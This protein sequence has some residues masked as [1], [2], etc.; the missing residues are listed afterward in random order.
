MNTCLFVLVLCS[1]LLLSCASN[2]NIII[3][4][5]AGLE[6]GDKVF[7]AIYTIARTPI[8]VDSIVVE[9]DGSFY[10]ETS[11]T[12][13]YAHL[14][15]VKRDQKFNLGGRKASLFI[16]GF[17]TM[18]IDGNI[19]ELY[20][21]KVTGGLY[22]MSD[23][24]MDKRNKIIES[25]RVAQKIADDKRQSFI[26]LRK[27]YQKDKTISEDTLIKRLEEYENFQK[28]SNKVLAQSK[29][30]DSTFR[31]NNPD[32]IYSAYVLNYDNDARRKGVEYYETLYNK[33]TP[34][35]KASLEGKSLGIYIRQWKATAIGAM[36]PDFKA[37]DI[38]GNDISL[39]DFRG[40]YILIEFWGRGCSGCVKAIPHLVKMY[41]KVKGEKFELLSVAIGERSEDKLL[42]FIAEK[43]MTWRN[44]NDS[45][46][47]IEEMYGI[48]TIPRS[49]LIDP[50]G[51]IIEK[52]HPVTLIPKIEKII[53][54]K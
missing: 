49:F 8:V 52:G 17:S 5:I 35:V 19:D 32:A 38:L 53:L 1:S 18:N 25:A 27:Q 12:D 47:E 36:A 48:K 30:L 24:E 39:T 9:K 20:Y 10:M 44:I 14:F 51:K 31:E 26:D 6:K 2:K 37:K 29:I 22:D 40:K 41:D 23:M 28:Q 15:M 43:K 21:A 45:K 16:E 33:L 7:L 13:A 3:G 4:H 42:D 11:A 54:E 50:E 46:G 34:R